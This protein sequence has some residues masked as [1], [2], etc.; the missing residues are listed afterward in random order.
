MASRKTPGKKDLHPN[1]GIGSILAIFLMNLTVYPFLILWTLSSIAMFPAAFLVWK[2]GTRW[3]AERIVRHFI[4]IY[5]RGWIAILSPFVRFG[6]KGLEAVKPLQPVIL[7]VNHLSFFD[8]YC[9]AL[10]PFHNVAF[11]IRSWPFRMYCYTPFMR[12]ANYLNVEGLK[13]ETASRL[14]REILERGG[15][16]LFFPE[17][18]RSR[19]GSLGRFYSGAFL[20]AME[21]GRPIV[22]MV[23]SGTDTLLPPNRWWLKPAR[24][25]LEALPPVD[26]KFFS[27]SGAH[28]DLKKAVKEAIHNRLMEIRS[29]SCKSL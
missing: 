24:I 11:A 20:L 13:W 1:M 21:T 16:T 25:L 26:P 23:I 19:D 29:V 22:P 18:H 8:T 10:L 15:N 14:A 6:R 7:V 12:L 28:I 9:M 2:A 3:T 5:G 4:W 17:G 27:G